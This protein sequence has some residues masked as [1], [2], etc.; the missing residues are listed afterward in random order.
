MRLDRPRHS[1]SL[2]LP[3]D[4]PP[5]PRLRALLFRRGPRNRIQS[6]SLERRPSCLASWYPWIIR[7]R[8]I[9]SAC[10]FGAP[11][12]PLKVGARRAAWIAPTA[13]TLS[14]ATTIEAGH[15][16]CCVSGRDMGTPI[17][18]SDGSCLRA[19]HPKRQGAWR[20]VQ[21]SWGDGRAI[22]AFGHGRGIKHRGRGVE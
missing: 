20:T 14:A 13:E 10:P 8:G 2:T 17:L 22:G 11:T 7:L 15:A 5:S 1:L 21:R 18:K 19:R 9:L 4:M 3:V 6:F 12:A 16:S